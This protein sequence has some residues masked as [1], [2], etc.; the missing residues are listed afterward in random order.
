MIQ[1]NVS[2]TER[3]LWILYTTGRGFKI[4]N[5]FHVC[6]EKKTTQP[7]R[8]QRYRLVNYTQNAAGILP[9]SLKIYLTIFC[10]KNQKYN[11][12]NLKNYVG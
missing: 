4:N 8:E 9:F 7:A 1:M 3:T 12:K 11:I 2:Q 6:G 5:I 10:H